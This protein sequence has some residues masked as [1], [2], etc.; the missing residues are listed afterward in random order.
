MVAFKNEIATLPTV[1]AHDGPDGGSMAWMTVVGAFLVVFCSS[2]LDNS[3]PVML[4]GSALLVFC[5]SKTSLIQEQQ[6]WQVFLAQGIGLGI[7][8]GIV[9]IPALGIV[10]HPFKKRRSLLMGIVGSGSSIS[11]LVHPIMLNQFFHGPI[12]F[13]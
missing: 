5:L 9:Y 4:A 8:V 11:G 1:D 10:S 3:R 2:R 7:A 12:G 6:F 13:R